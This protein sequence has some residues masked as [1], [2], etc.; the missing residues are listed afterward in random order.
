MGDV[1]IGDL[2][3]LPNNKVKELGGEEYTQRAKSDGGKSRS[4][5]YW[6]PKTGDV[7]VVLNGSNIPQYIDTIPLK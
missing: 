7:Y 2:K 1:D 6:N 5:L 3:R 4:N